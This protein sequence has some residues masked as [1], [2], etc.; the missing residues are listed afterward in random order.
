MRESPRPH[1]MKNSKIV[2]C[3][4]YVRSNPNK[5]NIHTLKH[6]NY[7]KDCISFHSRD[8]S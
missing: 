2:K 5:N 3:L 1:A 4:Y 6:F 8:N 7:E